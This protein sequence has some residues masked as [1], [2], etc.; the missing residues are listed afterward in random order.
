MSQTTLIRVRDKKM[1]R[2]DARGV[3][4]HQTSEL[5]RQGD[6]NLK[7]DSDLTRIIKLLIAKRKS[8]S[9]RVCVCVCVCNR[10]R[11]RYKKRKGVC[12]S[13]TLRVFQELV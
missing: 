4:E 12:R 6:V 13:E 3:C 9:A 10:E 1:M 11:C 5:I 8:L 2:K 7:Y